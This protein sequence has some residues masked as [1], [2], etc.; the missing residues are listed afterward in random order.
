MRDR[1]PRASAIRRWCCSPPSRSSS[2]C[3]SPTAATA[4]G[5]S[6]SP[7]SSPTTGCSTSTPAAT[8]RSR[9]RTRWCARPRRASLGWPGIKSVYTRVGG[10]AGAGR[11]ATSTRTWSAS[12]STSSSTGASARAPTRSSTSSAPAMTGIPGADVEVSVPNAGPPTGK[13]IQVQ[14]SAVD[15]GRPQRRRAQASPTRCAACPT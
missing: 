15:P 6:S 9:R 3:R 14:L 1:R 7:T 5:W 11:R 10:D 8:S 2:R 13:A 4:P 12:S